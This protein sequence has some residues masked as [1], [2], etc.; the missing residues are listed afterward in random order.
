MRRNDICTSSF[1][2]LKQCTVRYTYTHTYLY[3]CVYIYTLRMHTFP[4]S[5]YVHVDT[6]VHEYVCA[7][8]CMCVSVKMI[9]GGNSTTSTNYT[10]ASCIHK[11]CNL[12]PIDLPNSFNRSTLLPLS[13][14]LQP[15]SALCSTR[16]ERGE[17]SKF[18]LYSPC[19]FE[20]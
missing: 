4:H 10:P 1:V 18:L 11:Q 13:F 17:P 12:C 19:P 7:C 5:E 8:V 6:F 14:C 15:C 2:Y 16:A 3:L 9:T 20:Q